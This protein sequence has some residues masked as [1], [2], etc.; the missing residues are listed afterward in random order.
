VVLRQ[1]RNARQAQCHSLYLEAENRQPMT[2][3]DYGNNPASLIVR[4]FKYLIGKDYL[5]R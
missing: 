2:V 5:R 1:H 3:N 4:M